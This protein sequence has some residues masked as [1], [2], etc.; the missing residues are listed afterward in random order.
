MFV[1]SNGLL[2]LDLLIYLIKESRGILCAALVMISISLEVTFRY[3]V[4]FC[5]RQFYSSLTKINIQFTSAKTEECWPN[6]RAFHNAITYGNKIIIFGGHNKTVLQD[7][8]SFNVT[9]QKWAAVP[10]IAGKYPCKKE[11]Q[12]CVIYSLILPS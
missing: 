8:Y 9:E 4:G 1:T 5:R 12:S 10:H 6:G 11:K 7:Y 2:F 3:I